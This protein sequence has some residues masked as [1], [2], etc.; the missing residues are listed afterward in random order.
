[1]LIL[2]ALRPCGGPPIFLRP[3][4]Q[5]PDFTWASLNRPGR[6]SMFVLCSGLNPPI[7]AYQPAGPKANSR[8]CNNGPEVLLIRALQR[9]VQLTV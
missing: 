8:R 1:M 7:N 3:I 6:V 2:F 5:T 4:G 9:P